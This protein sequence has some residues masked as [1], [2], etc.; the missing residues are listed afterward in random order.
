MNHSVC[1]PLLLGISILWIGCAT[2]E[3]RY[4]TPQNINTN[5][6]AFYNE[7]SSTIPHGFTTYKYEDRELFIGQRGDYYM[8]ARDL[9]KSEARRLATE[10]W[11]YGLDKR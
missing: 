11:N 6:N 3:N 8:K 7:K 2:T 4:D 10:D 9:P 5:N 1:L